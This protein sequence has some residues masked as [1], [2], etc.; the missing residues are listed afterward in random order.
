MVDNKI[1]EKK[2]MNLF[3]AMDKLFESQQRRFQQIR[4]EI[5][6]S[7]V[8]LWDIHKAPVIKMGTIDDFQKSIEEFKKMNPEAQITARAYTFSSSNPEENKVFE[9]SGEPKRK[10]DKSIMV[11]LGRGKKEKKKSKKKK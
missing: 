10:P 6:K 11:E 5:D 3:E 4:E 1:V 9:Y 8:N 2:P 7:W